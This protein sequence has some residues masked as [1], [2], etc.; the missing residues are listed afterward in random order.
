[1][2]RWE[3]EPD[4]K[5]WIDGASGYDCLILRMEWSGHLTVYVRVP[6]GHPWHG[7]DYDAIDADVHGGLTYASDRRPMRIIDGEKAEVPDAPQGYW[8]GFD[9]AHLGDLT[10]RY[11]HET[12]TYRDM[13]YMAN[14]CALLAKQARDAA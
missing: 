11:P 14:E 6:V 5:F 3:N 10:P 7:K 1:M 4:M 8:V 9:A 2:N 13:D 12:D